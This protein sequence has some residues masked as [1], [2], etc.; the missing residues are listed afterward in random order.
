MIMMMKRKK[1]KIVEE[2]EQKKTYKKCTYVYIANIDKDCDVLQERHVLLTGRMPHIKKKL[3]CL[4][5]S[6]NLIRVP[7]GLSAKT[8]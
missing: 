2:K 8:D 7:E 6:Q 4:D 5:Y 3:H 1:K